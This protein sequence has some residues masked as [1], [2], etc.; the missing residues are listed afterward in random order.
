MEKKDSYL[1]RTGQFGPSFFCIIL[2]D[3]VHFTS[4]VYKE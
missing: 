4:K 3:I 1:I 2:Q